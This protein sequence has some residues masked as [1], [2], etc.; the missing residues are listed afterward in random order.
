MPTPAQPQLLNWDPKFFLE[1]GIEL[2][3][4]RRDKTQ[5]N[6]QPNPFFGFYPPGG[7]FHPFSPFHSDQGRH[8]R[9]RRKSSEESEEHLEL[10]HIAKSKKRHS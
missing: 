3:S 5:M 8:H 10:E 2:E 7:S 1:A 6:Q 9:R 4:L